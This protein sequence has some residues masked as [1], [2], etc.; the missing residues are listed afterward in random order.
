MQFIS[1]INI[2]RWL[3]FEKQLS[4]RI[5][6]NIFCD[7]SSEAYG[8]VAYVN[9]FSECPKKHISSFLLSKSRLAPIKEK[10]LTIPRL[11]L[12]AAVLAIRL[13]NT[14]SKQLDFSIDETRFWSDSQVVLKYIA[15]KDT[16]FPVFVMN[17]L[18][19]IHLHSTP[20][21]WHYVPTS[22]NPADFCTR[23]VPFNKLKLH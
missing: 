9:Y 11:E 23:F 18:N 13:K 7:A 12:Q 20:E 3:G 17:R 22:Q 14:I 8:A 1:D 2:P 10:S 15:N 19:E 16:R 6:L 5:E 21:Q 4:D